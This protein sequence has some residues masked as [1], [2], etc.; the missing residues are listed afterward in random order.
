MPAEIY[1]IQPL[2]WES[3][4]D[5]ERAVIPFGYY[6]ITTDGGFGFVALLNG[7]GLG[8]RS[9]TADGAKAAA[10]DDYKMRIYSAIEFV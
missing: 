8:L 6:Q 4:P 10:Q 9:I 5:G 7:D 1:R 2:E 3:M